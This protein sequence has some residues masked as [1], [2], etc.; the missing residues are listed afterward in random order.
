MS[1]I[2]IPNANS[3]PFGNP[4]GDLRKKKSSP[5]TTSQLNSAFQDLTLN[6]GSGDAEGKW[7]KGGRVPPSFLTSQSSPH[8]C[9]GGSNGTYNNS[10]DR[11]GAASSSIS[12]R[13]DKDDSDG[14]LFKTVQQQ[15]KNGSGRGR[16]DGRNTGY[17]GGRGRGRYNDG[18][19]SWGRG[20]GRDVIRGRHTCRGE[21]ISGNGKEGRGEKEAIHDTRI[22]FPKKYH[23]PILS[24]T[25]RIRS[26][27]MKQL[28]GRNPNT[29]AT[30][31]VSL[32][33]ND[34]DHLMY[35]IKSKISE[36]LVS[37]TTTNQSIIHREISKVAQ[38]VNKEGFEPWLEDNA[39][40]WKLGSTFD[41]KSIGYKKTL[42]AFNKM[43][44]VYKVLASIADK[45]YGI[46]DLLY[47]N[48]YEKCERL[49]KSSHLT[50][51]LSSMRALV[52]HFRFEDDVLKRKCN[53]SS[54][55]SRVVVRNNH[56]YPPSLF[57]SSSHQSSENVHLHR[58]RCWANVVHQ[59][60]TL[61]YSSSTYG[62]ACHIHWAAHGSK[63]QYPLTVIT[64]EVMKEVIDAFI[65][66]IKN[67]FHFLVVDNNNHNDNTQFNNRREIKSEG[68]TT[69]IGS[70]WYDSSKR[71]LL[72][73][74]NTGK[75][76]SHL[77]GFQ[78]E[79]QLRD[80]LN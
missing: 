55:S 16:G 71:R 50:D 28:S 9:L 18:G 77:V 41:S 51:T 36:P 56:K 76:E 17:S 52:E 39:T 60:N 43:Q 35:E 4:S 20:S 67:V 13:D 34:T 11:N 45:K 54:G 49:K 24:Q 33:F 10:N 22:M 37:M 61:W 2:S 23:E 66:I 68:D 78:N 59:C 58:A 1:R 44:D 42:D 53:G 46:R 74:T 12:L 69:T 73:W 19:R 48:E 65:A 75:K 80:L 64:E 15:N 70:I 26:I 57:P 79:Q 8:H 32:F 14:E 38:N 21:D 3:Y 31:F 40:G 5:D 63:N 72:D 7:K 27:I 6:T 62:P 30:V 47:K 29:P 25:S